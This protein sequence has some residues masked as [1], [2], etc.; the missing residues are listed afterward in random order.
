MSDPEVYMQIYDRAVEELIKANNEH[1]LDHDGAISFSLVFV[2]KILPKILNAYKDD[3]IA[4]EA[5]RRWIAT[6]LRIVISAVMPFDKF[7]EYM[8]TKEMKSIDVI[9]K[10]LEEGGAFNF[11]DSRLDDLFKPPGPAPNIY[12]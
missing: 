8:N 5:K 1:K 9:V 3:A 11:D 2:E 10:A 4:Y 6:S 12:G 7:M